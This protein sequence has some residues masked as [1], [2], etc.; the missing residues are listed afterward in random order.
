MKRH[1]SKLVGSALCAFALLV[2]DFQGE[3]DAQKQ[4]RWHLQRMEGKQAEAEAEERKLAEQ[5]LLLEV[6]AKKREAEARAKRME[7]EA[8]VKLLEAEAK[9]REAEAYAK[10]IEAEAQLRLLEAIRS[11][12]HCCAA[13]APSAPSRGETRHPRPPAGNAMPFH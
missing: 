13:T 1:L 10:L 5:R 7:A 8:Q 12:A 9:K 2:C 11:S 4:E 6:E 3:R